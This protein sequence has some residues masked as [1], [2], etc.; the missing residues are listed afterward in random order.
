VLKK[1]SRIV[2]KE[3]IYEILKDKDDVSGF[4]MTQM[5]REMIEIIEETQAQLLLEK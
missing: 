3:I 1:G 2:I 4:G 5:I